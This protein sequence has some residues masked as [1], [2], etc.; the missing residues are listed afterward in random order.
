MEHWIYIVYLF[1]LNVKHD[2]LWVSSGPFGQS[3]GRLEECW[4]NLS[5]ETSLNDF[6]F[7]H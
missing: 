4:D 2:V 6:I 7:E 5:G 1:C 3:S